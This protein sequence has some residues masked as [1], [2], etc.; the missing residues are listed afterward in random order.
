MG[1]EKVNKNR[2]EQKG[3]KKEKGKYRVL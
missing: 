1:E 3:G 2:V